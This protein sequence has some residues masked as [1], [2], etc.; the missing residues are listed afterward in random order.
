MWRRAALRSHPSAAPVIHKRLRHPV[1]LIKPHGRDH[2]F[3]TSQGPWRRTFS[4]SSPH[5]ATPP[6]SDLQAAPCLP[7]SHRRRPRCLF[8]LAPAP[9]ETPRL[10]PSPAAGF[11]GAR[12]SRPHHDDITSHPPA[13]ST[14]YVQSRR[15]PSPPFATH[16]PRSSTRSFA[17]QQRIRG[18]GMP[19]PEY[20]YAAKVK[21]RRMPPHRPADR[22]ENL[23]RLGSEPGS[24]A[25][26]FANTRNRLV[27]QFPEFR[28]L[29]DRFRRDPAYPGPIESVPLHPT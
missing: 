2:A 8:A 27:H 9:F 6:S 28:R 23:Q 4:P 18:A 29:Y 19:F 15:Y 12:P 3:H 11:P 26:I 25:G 21:C 24:S 20:H 16:P 17:A 10:P 13:S 14:L 1:L 7:H 5:R 22:P